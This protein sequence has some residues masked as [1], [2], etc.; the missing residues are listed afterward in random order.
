MV[1]SCLHFLLDLMTR[2]PVGWPI[3]AVRSSLVVGSDISDILEFSYV[4][5]VLL[6]GKWVILQ[7]LSQRLP[8][9]G[10]WNRHRSC[11]PDHVFRVLS[12]LPYGVSQFQL[13]IESSIL[14]IDIAKRMILQNLNLICMYSLT[15]EKI[16]AVKLD[17]LL[18]WV[19]SD[20]NPE[21]KNTNVFIC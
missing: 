9:S 1:S 7:P 13:A 10:M 5:S 4:F 19:V 20:L 16:V 18:F 2:E 11:H 15:T 14:N 8:N 12:K 21:L 6:R 3:E 17:S